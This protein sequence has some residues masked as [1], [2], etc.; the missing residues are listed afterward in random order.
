MR[1]GRSGRPLAWLAIG[2]VAVALAVGVAWAQ[3]EEEEPG[4]A[5]PP[6]FSYRVEATASYHY[7]NH[8]Y[9]G[10][11]WGIT[12]DPDRTNYTWGE[13]FKRLRLNY[14]LPEGLWVSAGGVVMTTLATDYYGTDGTAD[15]RVDQL[16]VGI[17][18]AG[19]SGFSLTAGRQD[20]QVGD[21][22][23]I[24][25]GFADSKAALW[26]IPLSFYDGLRAD[27]VRGPWHALALA[28]A[29]RRPTPA[30]DRR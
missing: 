29:C 28:P 21:G 8:A 9:F 23:V 11:D 7:V 17:E 15:G 16:A 27:L 2:C 4:P 5:V 22:F 19:G 18:N 24:G 26:N 1:E 13:A 10:A 25:D 12:S 20:L 14:G 30:R 3:E 6:G